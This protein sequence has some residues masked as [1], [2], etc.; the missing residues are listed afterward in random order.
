MTY[1]SRFKSIDRTWF[2]VMFM[3]YL[4][5]NIL[6]SAIRITLLQVYD[7]VTNYMGVLT[8][9]L[10]YANHVV[11]VGQMSA[12]DREVHRLHCAGNFVEIL[13]ATGRRTLS[14]LDLGDLYITKIMY[15]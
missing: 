5:I 9:F 4:E 15:L 11:L 6:R 12:I 7:V 3:N 1:I 8:V 10:S 14:E 2:Y 13:K